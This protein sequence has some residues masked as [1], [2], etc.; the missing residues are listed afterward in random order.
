MARVERIHLDE[1]PERVREISQTAFGLDDHNQAPLVADPSGILEVGVEAAEDGTTIAVLT[2][3]H[4]RAIPYFQWFFSPMQRG[5][6]RRSLRYATETLHATVRGD[7]PPAAPRLSPLT[8]PA[9]FGPDQAALLAAVCF[10]GSLTGFAA[11]IFG[12]FANPIAESFSLSNSGLGKAF[13]ITRAG[14]L[15]AL[16]AAAFADRIGRRRVLLGALAAVCIGSAA[17]AVA[18]NFE[19]LTVAQ[20]IVRAGVN[21]AL[22]V[23]GIAVVEQAP[24]GARAFSVAMLGLAAGA[25][26]ALSVA[27][28]PVAAINENTWRVGFA[29]AAL[30][31]VLVPRLAGKLPETQ[32]YGRLA[33]RTEQRGRVREVL[34]RQYGP[35]L[36]ILA[37]LG[38][39]ANVFSAPAAQFSNRYLET[40]RGFSS[41]EVA[42]FKGITNG[43]PGLVGILLAGRLAE[44]RGRRPVAVIGM[45]V[46]AA[47]SIVFFLSDGPILWIVSSIGIIAG[48]S[49]TLSVGT[50]DAEMFP[51]EVRG[52]ANGILLVCS[53]AGSVTG[54]LLVS[55]LSD[56][57]GSLGGAIAIC[58]IAPILA[59]LFLLP[60]LPE[61]GGRALDE[62]SPSEV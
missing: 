23:G 30:M 9:D 14:A 45:A 54:L 52:T 62:V 20:I 34:D 46:G 10:A 8:P 12:Q 21:T 16:F 27:L 59:A 42:G 31:I 47:L 19:F 35:R 48:A 3:R 33:A 51:T 43:I 29:V 1:T 49:G 5:A 57:I 28:L 41:G 15:V 53:V 22:V 4:E 32:R 13:A 56:R 50:M 58:G 44:T 6:R 36:A 7:E 26:Y 18:P 24:E 2:A 17:S 61:S 38:F 25:G 37:A 55:M 40:E 11:A 39:M 60:R